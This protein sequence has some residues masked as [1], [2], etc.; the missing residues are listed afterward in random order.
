MRSALA[1]L[2][3]FPALHLSYGLGSIVAVVERLVGRRRPAHQV[4]SVP[5]S[6]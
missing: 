6:R 5:L 4:A 1:L 2:A 3:V